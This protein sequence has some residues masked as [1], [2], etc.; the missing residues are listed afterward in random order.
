MNKMKKY[1]LFPLLFCIVLLSGLLSSCK[2]VD[3]AD[4][5]EVRVTNIARTTTA[6]VEI[7]DLQSAKR[8]G[9]VTPEDVTITF[10]GKNKND[11][12]TLSN[13]AI[14]QA[15]VNDGTLMFA[16]KD[17]IIPTKTNPVVLQLN[18]TSSNYLSIVKTI[19]IDSSSQSSFLVEMVRTSAD[20]SLPSGV[21]KGTSTGSASAS[22]GLTQSLVTSSSISTVNG[23]TVSFPTKTILKDQNG[24]ALSGTVTSNLYYF[25]PHIAN[26]SNII[27][28]G[29][30]A[31]V[32]T[33]IGG[34]TGG[35]STIYYPI[36]FAQLSVKVG[37]T[38]VSSIT[39]DSISLTFKIPAEYKN[40]YT[41][42]QIKSV[43]K[44][45]IYAYD[46]NLSTWKKI[47]DYTYSPSSSSG[48]HIFKFKTGTSII[49][50]YSA[51]SSKT[52]SLNKINDILFGGN[53]GFNV[54][55]FIIDPI[56]VQHPISRL[57]FSPAD[58]CLGNQ[59][60]VTIKN[61]NDNSTLMHQTCTISTDPLLSITGVSF[62]TIFT[63]ANKVTVI[64]SKPGSPSVVYATETITLQV[65]ELLTG[66]PITINNS[67]ATS[68]VNVH[69]TVTGKCSGNNG[70][71]LADAQG[72]PI[73]I[74]RDGE[75]EYLGEITD[76]KITINCLPLN[77]A[78]EYR[79][80]WKGKYV[81]DTNTKNY[82]KVMLTAHSTDEV[83]NFVITDPE[84]CK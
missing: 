33:T 19:V 58:A 65:L 76:G 31:V 2:I 69:V 78:Y 25:D 50:S 83:A 51:A 62:P 70:K 4:G 29:F 37:S 8:I 71:V 13:E 60:D 10:S 40:P 28:G 5:L 30:S 27:P 55:A 23:C 59:V 57:S 39:S 77:V 35:S 79:T 74:F 32:D 18:V 11:V 6:I 41:G 67:S 1:L 24:N 82:T 46:P 49:N 75:W 68:G 34:T 26:I 54:A 47:A 15:T 14:T 7:R 56:S 22:A 64:L 48:S 73:W 84:L 16:I 44:L 43:D 72:L 80:Q 52:K 53:S 38:P 20:A 12:I 66:Y 21:V 61:N 17:N 45:G 63:S 42:E 9:S 36:S 3:P 81:P